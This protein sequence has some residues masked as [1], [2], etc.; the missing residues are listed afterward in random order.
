M[1]SKSNA[2]VRPIVSLL[3]E[4]KY[5]TCPRE[6]TQCIHMP[7]I[8]IPNVYLQLERQTQIHTSI[9]SQCPGDS[10]PISLSPGGLWLSPPKS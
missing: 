2:T 8:H 7:Y 6:Q 1:N 4:N 3:L 9:H 5:S 10:V